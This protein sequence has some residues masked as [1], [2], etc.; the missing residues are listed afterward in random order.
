EAHV[1]NA[2]A[3]A[4]RR[5]NEI[6]Q[7]LHTLTREAERI[8]GLR[9]EIE[10]SLAATQTRLAHIRERL[11]VGQQQREAKTGDLREVAS[12][13]EQLEG[14]LTTAWA[15]QAELRARLATLQ[16]LEEG[17]EQ[18]PQGVRAIMANAGA[19]VGVRGVVAQVVEVPQL[20]ERAVAAV[21]REKLEYVVVAQV[22]D[23]LTAVAYLREAGAGRGSFIPLHPRVGHGAV[24]TNGNG[25]H[26]GCGHLTAATEEVKPLLDCLLVDPQYQAVAESLLGEA[27]L[28]PNLEA[29]FQLWSQNGARHTF[30]TLDG[31][32]ISPQ[33]I[34]SGGSEGFAEEAL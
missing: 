2:L 20:Y 9:A 16:E 34:I 14:E 10:Q 7:R 32:V 17:F 25:Y 30:V 4:R 6:E 12:S 18:Y 31:E 13:A 19:A 23:G 26:N 15:R 3:Y 29:G 11:V 24:Y 8:T 27:V 5:A 33:G 28:V 21:L 22:E 1:Q